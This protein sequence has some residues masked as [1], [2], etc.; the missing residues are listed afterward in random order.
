MEVYECLFM[1]LY[2]V[3]AGSA[4]GQ[5]RV[6]RTRLSEMI[7]KYDERR[8]RDVKEDID[9]LLVFVGLLSSS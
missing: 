8:L 9:S 5:E 7:R 4:T 1:P 6:G 2:W 3:Q